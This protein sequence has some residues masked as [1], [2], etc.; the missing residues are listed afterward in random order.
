MSETT[1][2]IGLDLGAESGRCYVAEFLESTI[3]LDEVY[4]F[5]THTVNNTMGFQWDI[6]AITNEIF[7]GLKLAVTKHGS[8]FKGIG[9]DTWGVDYVLIDSN[10]EPLNNPF[11]Y[12][13]KRTDSIMQKTFEIMPEKSIYNTTG[14]KPAQY[15]TLFQLLA[16]KESVNS[17]LNKAYKLLLMPDY[18]KFVLTGIIKSEY[19][20][21]T[22]TNLVDAKSG[23][24]S[25]NLIR[26]FNF[27]DSLF[28]EIIQPGGVL[29]NI[30]SSVSRITG[31]SKN[32]TVIS[33]PG[34]D[35]ACAVAAIPSEDD[36]FTFLS[37]GTWSIMGME[38]S[39]PVLTSAAYSLSFSNEGGFNNTIRFLKNIIGLWPLQ[40]CKRI[41]EQDDEEIYYR[42]L[43][44]E[45]I[46]YGNAHTW[47]DINDD[48]FLGKGNMPELIAECLPGPKQALVKNKGFITRLILESLAFSY[49]KTVDS[50]KDVTGE[51]IDK[52]YAV[53]G[54]IKNE[55]L[56]QL[57]ADATG[58]KVT[59]GPVEGTII[60][61]IGVQA[62][63]TG[64]ISDL[65][66]FRNIVSKTF[67]PK[68]YYPQNP[69][70]FNDNEST[71][72]DR[73]TK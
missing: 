28:S 34:H 46:K 42:T 62:L 8:V 71:Y 2:F 33:T 4:R 66:E 35:T 63:A 44:E 48:K 5:P 25:H 49:R 64:V 18:I 54:G 57:T 38:L 9:V 65:R 26:T 10:G 67:K 51:P 40:E 61:N 27:P 70:Y 36:R 60:G 53:G 22:T 30:Q 17:N 55:L 47:I 7:Q 1:K 13:D 14:N 37:S 50:L 11:H 12:R 39:K 16:E 45:A 31:L 24:W 59:A 41:W 68:Q 6:R 23:D 72:E 21:A 29:G 3:N 15:N 52:L 56:N 32:T 20:I 58:L 73:I 43:S 19:T 69:E